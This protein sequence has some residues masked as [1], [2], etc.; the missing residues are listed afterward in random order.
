MKY[1]EKYKLKKPDVTDSYNIEDFNENADAIDKALSEKAP[2]GFGLGTMCKSVTSIF[3][4]KSN[5]WWLTNGDTPDGNYWLCLSFTANNTAD[6]NPDTIVI[7]AKSVTGNMSARR[8]KINGV[9]GP[10]EWENPPLGLNTEYRTTER[11]DKN[12]VY[13]KLVLFGTGPNKTE[14]SVSHNI[15]R[16]ANVIEWHCYNYNSGTNIEQAPGVDY[17]TVN[18]TDMIISSVA[19]TNGNIADWYIYFIIKYTKTTD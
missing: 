16:I 17:I 1:T 3:D 13:C 12:P 14:K 11:F 4:I 6:N 10:W 15:S 2:A 9:W 7:Q 5:G 18:K 8:S 19:T